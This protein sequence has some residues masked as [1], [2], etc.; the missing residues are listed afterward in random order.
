MKAILVATLLALT[1]LPAATAKPQV[2]DRDPCVDQG[3]TAGSGG[4]NGH[5]TVFVA[6][7]MGVAVHAGTDSVY[8][9]YGVGITNCRY[10]VD[11]Q[12]GEPIARC[13]F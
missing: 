3:A 8:V 6:G 2:C 4:V 7:G 13:V 5:V 10:G 11:I 9:A 12:N 1:L